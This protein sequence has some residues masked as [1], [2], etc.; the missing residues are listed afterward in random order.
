MDAEKKMILM[1][2]DDQLTAD[3][4]AAMI[5][6][7]GQGEFQTMHA[8]NLADG[9]QLLA[10]T[11]INLVLLDLNLPDSC[12]VTTMERMHVAAPETAVIVM[13]GLSD[14]TIT[15][16]ALHFGAQD[17]LVKG[18]IDGKL[19]LQAIRYAIERKQ[20]QNEL[21]KTHAHMLQQE[22]MASIGQLAAG[23]AHEINNPIGFISSNLGTLNKYILRLLEFVDFVDS[24]Q[25]GPG[26]KNRDQ[27]QTKREELK[28]DFMINDINDLIK[29]SL[30]GT[31]RVKKIVQDL[32][33]FSRTDK[34]ECEIADINDILESTI[35]MVWN[36]IKYKA[37]LQRKFEAL[38]LTRCNP[39][40]LN[41][42]FV[43]LLI[44]AAQAIEDHG[45]ITVKTWLSANKIFIA[46]SDTGCGIPSRLTT[47]LFE[48]FFTTKE[49]G[50][51]TGL[52]L[53]IAYEIIA[54]KHNGN[55]M[56]TSEEGK[57]TTFT[58]QIPVIEELPHE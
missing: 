9:L 5:E 28:V 34:N 6:A 32:K 40:Q 14:D 3:S 56:V 41:Q 4:M 46:I 50:K 36:E 25:Q 1:I 19:L 7:L 30:Q 47:R 31:E 10:A 13:T 12:G 20:F 35:N 58:V 37:T 24:S 26:E 54:Q 51:G 27:I 18:Q 43:N 21:K 15:T 48:P 42:V 38:P 55:I 2:E 23:V 17:Y 39:Q 52:G 53:S 22:K 8:E 57:G 29:E 33:S 49:V 45:E 16:Q 44:N 11:E